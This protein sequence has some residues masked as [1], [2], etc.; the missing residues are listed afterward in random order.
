MWSCG[1]DRRAP[2]VPVGGTPF[3]DRIGRDV[4]RGWFDNDGSW[5]TSSRW[6]RDLNAN[7][8]N[9]VKQ[10]LKKI[11]IHLNI[12]LSEGGGEGDKGDTGTP[13]NL[14]VV[15][16]KRNRTIDNFELLE[17][18]DGRSPEGHRGQP[19]RLAQLDNM[20]TKG[21]IAGSSKKRELHQ[22]LTSRDQEGKRAG[23]LQV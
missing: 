3:P 8:V 1:P 12:E 2:T 14:E 11:T 21:R 16:R 23:E 9:T 19:T 6:H 18:R 15:V 17:H 22:S 20:G 10:S 4:T 7:T 13:T 5:R